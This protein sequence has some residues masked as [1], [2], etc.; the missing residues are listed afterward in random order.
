MTI[1]MPFA[2]IAL[3]AI[4]LGGGI[5]QTGIAVDPVPADI[6][7]VLEGT[8]TL[9]EWHVDGTVMRPPDMTGRWMVH[10]GVVMAIRHRDGPK[11]FESTAAWGTYRITATEWIYGYERSEDATGP[12]AADARVRVRVTRPIPMQAWKIRRDGLKLFLERENSLRWEFDGP[13]LTL[14]SANGQI[15]R[16]Y[17]KLAP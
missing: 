2:S 14:Y 7:S 15:L 3:M 13:I 4:A 12:S 17:R 16:R 6:Q 8:W 10:D 1:L 9:E 11:A 5:R